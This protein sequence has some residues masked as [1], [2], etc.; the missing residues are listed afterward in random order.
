MQ[1]ELLYPLLSEATL[2][3]TVSSLVLSI[4]RA[5]NA[6]QIADQQIARHV[7]SAATLHTSAAGQLSLPRNHI[8]RSN[9][10]HLSRADRRKSKHL[11]EKTLVTE[12]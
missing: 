11:E 1:Y 7:L 3:M 8:S 6:W 2:V 12:A 9:G 10:S 4:T 5:Q